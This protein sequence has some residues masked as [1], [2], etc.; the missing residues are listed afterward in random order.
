MERITSQKFA[1]YKNKLGGNKAGESEYMHDFAKI[2][3]I[4]NEGIQ[5]NAFLRMID[6]K[7]MNYPYRWLVEP[8]QIILLECLKIMFKL[9]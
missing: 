1:E 7:C 3:S 5:N 9:A 8:I 6:V 4:L 2:E